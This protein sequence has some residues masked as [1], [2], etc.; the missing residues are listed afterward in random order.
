MSSAYQEQSYN[1]LILSFCLYM[2]YNVSI[3]F[4]SVIHF[5]VYIKNIYVSGENKT[6]LSHRGLSRRHLVEAISWVQNPLEL[7]PL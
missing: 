5:D 2:I 4:E 1:I 3:N 6:M 7:P